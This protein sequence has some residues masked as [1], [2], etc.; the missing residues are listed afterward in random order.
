MVREYMQAREMNSS[1][2]SVLG[3]IC[4]R[5]VNRHFAVHKIR[6]YKRF[7]VRSKSN[8]ILKIR[9]VTAI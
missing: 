1:L 8:I 6:T 9:G 7:L 4:T 3:N 5:Y 2:S